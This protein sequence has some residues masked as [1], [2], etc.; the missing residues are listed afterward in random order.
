MPSS[1]Y[2]T[3][4]RLAALDAAAQSWLGTPF[5]ANSAVP[6]PGGGVSCHNLF[7]ELHF[8]TGFM[9]RF[10]V[11]HGDPAILQHATPDLLLSRLDAGLLHRGWVPFDLPPSGLCPLAS[12]FYPVGAL[13]VLRYG[14]S[15]HHLVTILADERVIHVT[16]LG[17][18][19][20][21]PLAAL[22]ANP[23]VQIAALRLPGSSILT[24]D[25]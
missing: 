18:V 3:P 11:P 24:P 22:T 4:A 8:A 7:A 14:R 16:R 2:N 17:G 10:V 19:L 6:G 1:W 13:A 20:I 25:S 23:R 9:P 5:M 21:E 15:L 12:G